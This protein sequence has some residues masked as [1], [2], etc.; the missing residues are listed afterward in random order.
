[1]VLLDF[2]VNVLKFEEQPLTIEFQDAAGMRRTYTPDVLIHYRRDITPAKQMLP[3]LAEVKYRRD[4]F[5]NWNE[6]KPKFKAARAF[7]RAQGWQFQILTENEIRT[8]FLLNARFLRSYRSQLTNA[9]H[10]ELLLDLMHELRTATPA[11]ILAAYSSDRWE[12]AAILP[13]LW[14]LLARRLIK[15]DLT[16]K[17]TM[18][19]ELWSMD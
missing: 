8:D 9:E 12:Q 7:A 15:T 13:S 16:V 10:F 4:L 14:N 6:L 5:K 17:L 1:M 11:Q 3:L 18:D 2:D 19:S